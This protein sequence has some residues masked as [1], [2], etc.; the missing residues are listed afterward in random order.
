[1]SFES[2]L[3]VLT[4][5]IIHMELMFLSIYSG[6]LVTIVGLGGWEFLFSLSDLFISKLVRSSG[7][8]EGELP[9]YL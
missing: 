6:S 9:L 1:M 5:F 2:F 7:C 3:V 4:G 8:G